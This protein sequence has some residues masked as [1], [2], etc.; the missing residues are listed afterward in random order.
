MSAP[1]LAIWLLAAPSAAEPAYLG[2]TELEAAV[3][4]AARPARLWAAR[5]R[6]EL[7]RPQ[8][9]EDTRPSVPRGFFLVKESARF[10]FYS[11]D[12]KEKVDLGK[13]ERRLDRIEE[14]LGQRID[15]RI[16]YYYH[17]HAAF[18][19]WATGRY[20]AGVAYAQTGVIHSTR[21]LHEH[22]VVH[23]VAAYL[24][25]PPSFFSEGLAVALDSGGR[26]GGVSVHRWAEDIL[27]RNPHL[28]SVELLVARFEGIEESVRY[29]LAGSFVK[30]LIEARSPAHV[31]DFFRRT[32]ASPWKDAFEDAFGVSVQAAEEAWRRKL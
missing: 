28:G 30:R 19:A 2:E 6:P 17:E 29:P 15:R 11:R 9:F 12:P 24:G 1:L 25:D 7:P 3:G 32:R 14:A 5:E 13:A 8:A 16:H 22:E 27:R 20:A 4:L 10:S 26:W 23:L 18:V 21:K 31:A